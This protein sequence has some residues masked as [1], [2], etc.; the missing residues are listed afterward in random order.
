MSKS[1]LLAVDFFT[2]GTV[3]KQT[4]QGVYQSSQ[5]SL[6][7]HLS[8]RMHCQETSTDKQ[9]VFRRGCLTSSC[10]IVFH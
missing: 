10:F 1:P 9:N 2:F 4:V 7:D 5:W 3:S 8:K 6:A